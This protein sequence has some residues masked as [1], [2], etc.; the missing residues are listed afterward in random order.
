MFGWQVS[1]KQAAAL[2]MFLTMATGVFI[3]QTSSPSPE[4]GVHRDRNVTSL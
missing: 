2:R 1:D 3:R 4:R